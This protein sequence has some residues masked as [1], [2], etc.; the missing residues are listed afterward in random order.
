MNIYQK[1]I[2]TK[3]TL[4]IFS[5]IFAFSILV[6]WGYL[7]YL[8]MRNWKE[9]INNINPYYVGFGFLFIIWIII[10][11]WRYRDSLLSEIED[12]ENTLVGHFSADLRK[13]MLETFDERQLDKILAISRQRDKEKEDEE[14]NELQA[15]IKNIKKDFHL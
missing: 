7:I 13:E 14:K 1:K 11:A 15:A 6:I 3:K 2:K 8:M 12:I 9:F 10:S 4:F 5:Y